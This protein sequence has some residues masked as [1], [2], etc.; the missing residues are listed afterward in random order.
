MKEFK[1]SDELKEK[2]K[3]LFKFDDA[4][5]ALAEQNSPHL[6]DKVE[7]QGVQ[8]YNDFLDKSKE[9]GHDPRQVNAFLNYF[10]YEYNWIVGRAIDE[11]EA[12]KKAQTQPNTQTEK[13]NE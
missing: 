8:D 11:H 3:Y 1:Y 2:V 10:E 5:I 6:P 13:E 4:V 9:A 7:S 12:Y